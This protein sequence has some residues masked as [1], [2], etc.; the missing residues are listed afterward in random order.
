MLNPLDRQGFWDKIDALVTNSRVVID[1]P[2]GAP[3]PH[4]PELIYPLDYGYLEGTTAQDG[5]AIDVWCGSLSNGRPEGV[6]LTVDL[7]KRDTELKLLLG[8]TEAEMETAAGFQNNG[9]MGAF[10]IRRRDIPLDW[11]FSR[12]SVRRFRPEPVPRALLERVLEAAQWAPSAHNR[13]PWRFAVLTGEEARLK[14]GEAMGTDFRR[15]LLASGLDPD[16]VEQQVERSCRR[17]REAPAAV[18][19]CLDMAEMDTYPD[20]WRQ[21]AEYLMAVQ[22]I[23]MA[24]ENLLLAAHALGLGGVWVCAP[25]FAQE[26]ARK[27]LELPPGWQPQG[28]ILLGY[29]AKHPEARPRKPLHEVTRFL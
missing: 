1:R 26:S 17:I 23:A 27:V 14:L 28:L 3:H 8:C 2:R 12:R 13:Q 20:S 29:P 22:S 10:L 18:L 25:L 24:G 7:K 5:G 11:I 4:Y 19:L 21:E 16:E 15:D 6:I 9:S